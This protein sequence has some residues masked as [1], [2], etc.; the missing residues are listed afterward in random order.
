[1]HRHLGR[2]LR[3]VT[4]VPPKY[5]RTSRLQYRTASILLLMPPNQVSLSGSCDPLG[6]SK[7]L[8]ILQSI[9]PFIRHKLHGDIVFIH[10]TAQLCQ[11][12]NLPF[13]VPKSMGLQCA[14]VRFYKLRQF[15]QYSAIAG[16]FWPK[17][18]PMVPNMPTWEIREVVRR[19][20]ELRN[21]VF[22]PSEILPGFSPLGP[23]L[24][25]LLNKPCGRTSMALRIMRSALMK[26]SS[27][28]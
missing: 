21:P 22:Q 5:A 8:D 13:P 12:F 25:A 9:A 16:I 20:S 24:I 28:V 10:I 11:T 4:Q 23:S 15:P 2:T 6:L 3:F 18:S 27:P 19:K 14:A 7:V 1:M 26:R 17:A